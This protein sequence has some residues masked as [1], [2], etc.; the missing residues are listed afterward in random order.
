[1]RGTS[2]EAGRP[3][4]LPELGPA[5]RTALAAVDPDMLFETGLEV[6]LDGIEQ[7]LQRFRA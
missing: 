7:R 3:G 1:V 4:R 5:G 2:R 6:L